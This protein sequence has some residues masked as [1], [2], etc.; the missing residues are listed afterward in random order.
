MNAALCSMA[1]PLIAGLLLLMSGPGGTRRLGGPVTLGVSVASG[2]LAWTALQSTQNNA[3]QEMLLGGWESGLA[4]RLEL[5]A[6][7]A[8][9]LLF[10]ALIHGLVALYAQFSRA[11]TGY[12]YWPLSC[13]LHGTLAALWLSADLFNLYV[14]LELLGLVSLAL[15][16]KSGQR[17]WRP[18]L[19]YLLLSL[20]GALCYLLGVA[21]LYG[22]YG[23]LDL[24]LLAEMVRN[25]GLTRV[26][27]ALMTGGLMLKAALWPLH[28]WLPAAHASA[29]TAVSALLSALVVKGPLFI[30]WRLWSELAPE[31]LALRAGPLF[32]MTGIAALLGGGYS[33]LRSPY[34]KTIVAYSTVAQLGYA[35]MALGLLLFWQDPRM[36]IALWLFVIA[37]GLAKTSLFMAAGEIQNTL[38]TRRI[39]G[40]RGATQTAP[41]A[42][43][44]FSVAGGSLIGLPPSG[45]FL[46]K[47]VLLAPL[48]EDPWRWPW[49]VGILLGT[50]MS[51]AYVFRA[52]IMSFDRVHVE[53]SDLNPDRLAHWL[54]LVPALLV[55]AMALSSNW[56]LQWLEVGSV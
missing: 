2:I 9:L 41:V 16:V 27:L 6:L 22:Q 20:A 21:L 47:W 48:L 52:V 40:L 34:I 1:A 42:M 38:G 12:A 56:L 44:A 15:L 19:N 51:A 26:A 50:L 13:L 43:F 14:T 28:G 17:A 31:D 55:W 29:P 5:T 39:S 54:A 11:G 46:A 10:T 49:A 45:G 33:A 18:A 37:H 24:Q 53:H 3:R 7:S 25:D 32:A 23:V 8:L 4:I 36:H 30:L 35:M